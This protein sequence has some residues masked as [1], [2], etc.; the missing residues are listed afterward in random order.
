MHTGLTHKGA[1]ELLAKYGKNELQQSKENT[2][3]KILLRQIRTNPVIYLMVGAL[4]ISLVVGKTSTAYVVLGVIIIVISV[5]FFQEF[6]AERSIDA[7]KQMM[8]SISTVRRDNKEEEIDTKN[9]VPGDIIILR[10]GDR[11]PADC[12]IL[13]E[14][15]L[16]VNESALTGESKEIKKSVEKSITTNFTQDNMVYM[17]TFI[18][19]GRCVVKAVHTG[20]NTK[21]GN[22]AKTI[23]AVEKELPLQHKVNVL[24]KQLILLALFYQ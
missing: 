5:G 11:V 16:R 17:G 1:E 8:T 22:I 23:S 2:S 7:L 15:E 14:K 3:I 13:E 20:M 24:I 19:A 18:I 4:I 9:I 12:I 6:K 10:T 21:F